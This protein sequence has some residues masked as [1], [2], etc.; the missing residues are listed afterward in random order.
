MNRLFSHNREHILDNILIYN[1]IVDIANLKCTCRYLDTFISN[2][3]NLQNHHYNRLCFLIIRNFD[4]RY[5]NKIVQFKSNIFK[6]M[7]TLIHKIYSMDTEAFK[8]HLTHNY[9]KNHCRYPF[10]INKFITIFYSA[11]SSYGL[12]IERTI[13]CTKLSVHSQINRYYHDKANILL[14]ISHKTINIMHFRHISSSFRYYLIQ[15]YKLV[16]FSRYRCDTHFIDLSIDPVVY[17]NHKIYPYTL[18]DH[19]FDEILLD[20]KLTLFMNLL[21]TRYKN[22]YLAAGGAI[23][24]RIIKEIKIDLSS[25]IDLFAFGITEEQHLQCIASFVFNL[26]INEI[27]FTTNSDN[28]NPK[29]F[30][31]GEKR[32]IKVQF[33]WNH[34]ATVL[35]VLNR[36]DLSICQVGMTLDGSVY[37]TNAWLFTFMTRIGFYFNI[38]F[39]DNFN[40]HLR[41]R[42][43]IMRGQQIWFIPLTII[44][45][46]FDYNT[47][48]HSLFT[49]NFRRLY[50]EHLPSHMIVY[51]LF[52]TAAIN[53]I[54]HCNQNWDTEDSLLIFIEQIISQY[55]HSSR[56]Q[57]EGTAA[58][59]HCKVIGYK[60]HILQ[61]IIN[62]LF[63]NIRQV[64][65]NRPSRCI[66]F[67]SGVD[68]KV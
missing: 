58:S 54:K 10:Y 7:N 43:Y 24:T 66:C 15:S 31:F 64:R 21:P 60:S 29:T 48:Q 53:L 68:T 63:H 42:K 34:A 18:N 33:I 9:C 50:K 49:V 30:W 47:K 14:F 57:W 32:K 40:H 13:N 59:I 46:Y 19:F 55:Y 39:A 1:S 16:A 2:N 56:V 22:N 11:Y 12:Q 38:V 45:K 35:S 44:Y 3:I 52:S 41:L 17:N 5:D 67:W 27:P 23:V 26:V 6:F 20:F 8:N 28:R 65:M 25:D 51:P 37:Y 62:N 36:F 4:N 61:T